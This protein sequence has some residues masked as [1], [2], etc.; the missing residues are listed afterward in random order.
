[1]GNERRRRSRSKWLLMADVK[2]IATG[3]KYTLVTKNLSGTGVCLMGEAALE[4]GQKL[5]LAFDL[6][7]R[8]VSVVVSGEV[9]WIMD[10]RSVDVAITEAGIMF[11]NVS[12][13]MREL[14]EK[15]GIPD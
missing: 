15:V 12:S 2:N 9:V 8:D 4:R 14:L 3:R 11:K 1:M 5:E 7:D 10:T 6:P 13:P